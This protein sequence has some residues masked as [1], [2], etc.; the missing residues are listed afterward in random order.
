MPPSSSSRPAR[1]NPHEANQIYQPLDP[2][3]QTQADS[4]NAPLRSISDQHMQQRLEYLQQ[5]YK[6]SLAAG[7][8]DT[9][10]Q[11][12]QPQTPT[13]SG[14]FAQGNAVRPNYLSMPQSQ[15][16]Y[17]HNTS[18]QGGYQI[19]PDGSEHYI[20]A[21]STLY[22]NTA[23][24]I[25]MRNR[26]FVTANQGRSLTQ[27]HHHNA[28]N[29]AVPNMPGHRSTAPDLTP[30]LQ[31]PQPFTQ[32]PVQNSRSTQ[33]GSQFLSLSQT[34]NHQEA[35]PLSGPGYPVPHLAQTQ[36]VP[37]SAR[38]QYVPA[39]EQQQNAPTPAQHQTA[40]PYV[41]G[42]GRFPFKPVPAHTRPPRVPEALSTQP[43]P[44]L[45]LASRR[46]QAQEQPQQGVFQTQQNTGAWDRPVSQVPRPA[47]V[48]TNGMIQQAIR[49]GNRSRTDFQAQLQREEERMERN[50]AWLRNSQNIQGQLQALD[51]SI[52][53]TSQRQQ[54]Q[55]QPRQQAQLPQQQTQ[56]DGRLQAQ[57]AYVNAPG[58]S[59]MP[60]AG[61]SSLFPG[62]SKDFKAPPLPAQD[63]PS[64]FKPM[65]GMFSTSVPST[66]QQLRPGSS[67]SI[68]L[69]QGTPAA[70]D[71]TQRRKRAAPKSPMDQS[72]PP[73][74]KLKSRP[75]TSDDPLASQARSRKASERRMSMEATKRGA[76]HIDLTGTGPIISEKP[77]ELTS[78][79]HATSADRNYTATM[80][81]IRRRAV[82]EEK[83]AA[84][85]PVQMKELVDL[86]GSSP[87]P[88]GDLSF[89][90]QSAPGP[91]PASTPELQADFDAL[92]G[93]GTFDFGSSSRSSLFDD[94]RNSPVFSENDALF[95]SRAAMEALSSSGFGGVKESIPRMMNDAGP[96]TWND[97]G[98]PAATIDPRV[99]EV[100][101][102]KPIK[103]VYLKVDKRLLARLGL[104]SLIVRLKYRSHYVMAQRLRVG[105]TLMPEYQL[106]KVRFPEILTFTPA[107]GFHK[108]QGFGG[109]RSGPTKATQP[110]IHLNDIEGPAVREAMVNFPSTYH[111]SL[112][113]VHPS[114]N[115][116]SH[117]LH[118]NVYAPIHAA[119]LG[120][121]VSA[122]HAAALAKVRSPDYDYSFSENDGVDAPLPNDAAR[123]LCTVDPDGSLRAPE[124]P[125][126]E[127]R[128][129]L[130]FRLQQ[131]EAPE[132]RVNHNDVV[133][134]AVSAKRSGEELVTAIRRIDA[135]IAPGV[136]IR[137][138]GVETDRREDMVFT[139]W[140]QDWVFEEDEVV[141]EGKKKQVSK[142]DVGE[143]AESKHERIDEQFR[144]MDLASFEI[145]G[146][147]EDTFPSLSEGLDPDF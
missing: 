140:V 78:A 138:E 7:T 65:F 87:V 61:S 128:A 137:K 28:A 117:T 6:D 127:A 108:E 98:P 19:A 77:E 96:S 147:V 49:E 85:E 92:F 116:A 3:F 13:T 83:A 63:S 75:S 48:L 134:D 142:K 143:S 15:R 38:S 133:F 32:G 76:D 145:D 17:G 94:T 89:E 50:R 100:P 88:E 33:P 102:P 107:N 68:P 2:Q 23:Q 20:P 58:A 124:V 144:C 67:A 45:H 135:H 95:Y 132:I 30:G 110:G 72:K 59:A 146:M 141:D 62:L 106:P 120:L 109:V 14:G 125:W 5:Q 119:S 91:A 84:Q 130:E 11:S 43:A 57:R 97:H 103:M 126:N 46:I 90:F 81:Q 121:P 21:G 55:Q 27:R 22:I 115:P 73:P 47:P 54:A 56:R 39:P 52:S 139:D 16:D 82:D 64:T 69:T 40:Q 12:N 131:A 37:S 42:Q 79:G 111:R 1:I 70:T 80:D 34:P 35:G 60:L 105:L 86:T 36:P 26:L 24:D 9:N 104:P 74:T 118:R 8:F 99:L 66:K 44:A 53:S 129:D 25:D 31:V 18:R 4:N 123:K 10:S 51:R 41:R 112:H 114:E 71:T 29:R 136:D 113:E 93:P 122:E 101:T